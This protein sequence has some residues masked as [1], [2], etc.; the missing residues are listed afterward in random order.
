MFLEYQLDSIK[1]VE[2]LLIAKFLAS[3]IIFASPSI[4]WCALAHWLPTPP[5]EFFRIFPTNNGYPVLTQN[6]FVVGKYFFTQH[7]WQT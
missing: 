4:K 1:I 6:C 2:V 3:A 5:C 7:L